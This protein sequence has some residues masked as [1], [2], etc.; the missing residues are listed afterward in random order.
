[1][2]GQ[3]GVCKPLHYTH[4]H[5]HCTVNLHTTHTHTLAQTTL[6]HTHAHT[7]Y[8]TLHYTTH[9]YMHTHT[10][11]TTHTHTQS[12]A[13]WVASPG[14]ETTYISKFPF[15]KRLRFNWETTLR[16]DYILQS[17]NT[18]NKTISPLQ[19]RT[20]SLV[21]TLQ[22]QK[23]KPRLPRIKTWVPQKLYM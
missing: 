11:Y 4:G 3:T 6:H 21:L 17:H 9:T 19:I 10:H 2:G 7:N 20:N 16:S 23:R 14:P 18:T 1:M 5:I 13:G 12:K 15:W 8:T 22:I